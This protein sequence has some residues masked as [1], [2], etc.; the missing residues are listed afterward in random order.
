MT[1][2][3]LITPASGTIYISGSEAQTPT[4]P[5]LTN[6]TNYLWASGTTLQ[7][8][9]QEVYTNAPGSSEI[10]G[11]GSANQVAY[12]SASTTIAGS[13]NLTFD[14]N[15]LKIADDKKLLLGDSSD[16]QLYHSAGA[17]SYFTNASNGLIIWNQ[18]S[19]GGQLKLR[20]DR[21]DYGI[22]FDISGT[23]VARVTRV[24]QSEGRIGIG[25]TAPSYPLH[26]VRA[27]GGYAAQFEASGNNSDVFRL[28]STGDGSTLRFQTDH[29]I[30]SQ[31][32]HIGN[33][34]ASIYLRTS[35][36]KVG[37]GTNSPAQ[38]LDV[39]TTD[40][41]AI[42]RENSDSSI[43]G[44]S[45]Y[46]QRKRATGGDL[47]SGDLIGNL[48][49]QPYKGDYDNRA[50]TISAAVEGTIGTDTTPGRL[51]FSTAGAGANTVTERMR[52]DS[53]GF[54]GIGTTA[55]SY[56][57]HVT[58]ASGNTYG[59]YMFNA[60][61]RGI[62]FGDT[63][64]DGSGYGKISGVGGSLFL[65]S[66]QIYTSFLGT[67]D[68]S[69]TLG[70]SNRRWG[71]FFSRY[72]QFGY[73]SAQAEDVSAGGYVLGVSG[74]ADRHPFMVKAY[75]QTTPNLIVT[76]G[77]RVGVGTGSPNSKMTVQGDLD[78]PRGSR[79]R[80]GSTDSNQGIDIYHNNDGS[81]AFNGNVVFEGRS[82]GGDVVF[83]NLDHGQGYQFHAEN[84][85][86]TEQEIL[87]IDG[88]NARV[89]I[90][91]SSPDKTFVIR[92]GGSRDFKFYDY[93]MTYESSLGIRAKNGGYLG[94][95]TEGDNSVFIS[96]NGFA[97][98]RLVVNSAGNVGIG[99]TAP[100]VKLDVRGNTFVSGTLGTLAGS[101]VSIGSDG[102]GEQSL[103]LYSD[104]AGVSL[105][106]RHYG[107]YAMAHW[108]NTHYQEYFDYKTWR[109][110]GTN[111]ELMRLSSSGDLG[112]GTVAPDVKLDVRGDTNVSGTLGV[113]ANV[114]VGNR[115]RYKG[116]T[117]KFLDFTGDGATSITMAGFQAIRPATSGNAAGN[118]QDLGTTSY[119][120]DKIYSQG[121]TLS[122]Q[123]GG[124]SSPGAKTIWVSGSDVYWGTSKL[125]GQSGG[126][127][128]GDITAVTAGTNLNGGGS[129]GDVTLNL[130]TNITGDITFDTNV[131][132]V[133]SSNNLKL[134]IL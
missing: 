77:A 125:N 5:N 69:V 22:V 26:V 107:N 127:G 62:S 89:G 111:A 116:G 28:R 126:G 99:T 79:F 40:G 18:D 49:F 54:V 50:A 88:D 65:G 37:I 45:L 3:V 35:G 134:L 94:L 58:H 29:I 84:S 21:E 82:S 48:T 9:N 47:S 11:G 14:G 17:S 24:S 30:P 60:A 70:S 101:D 73:S 81:S 76:S 113:T 12:Y 90:N 16:L 23:E 36:H 71:Y 20:N 118:G 1:I 106:M 10:T 129:T 114:D 63:N 33:D 68:S 75:G 4:P 87:R 8:G 97:N 102:G 95:V 108:G 103:R 112:I 109:R 38:P 39:R 100:E 130:D 128:G 31:A 52:I 19:A 61:S 122:N 51:M 123:T 46:I 120:W 64:N 56:P 7:W 72:G 13:S 78:I 115:V 133:D 27:Q 96:T 74:N 2:D 25:T 6:G 43:Y 59:I 93:D 119:P 15:N 124:D 110:Q 85:S 41:V 86:G 80:A 92:T 98:K 57:L 44:P 42:R 34:N 53:A 121:L 67:S 132:S 66:S 55:P 104:S 105:N 117:T 32:L 91:N 131:L 83:R